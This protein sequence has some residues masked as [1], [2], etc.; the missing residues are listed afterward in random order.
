MNKKLQVFISSTFTDLIE[1]RQA[2]VE[3]ILNSGHI[4]AGMELFKGG[5]SI[6]KTIHKWIDESD[7][8]MLIL[9]G[10]YGAI[11]EKTGLSFTELEYNYAISKN[12]PVFAIV[13]D[14]KFLIF[15]DKCSDGKIDI[16]EQDHI[17]E[18]QSFKKNVERNVVKYVNNI[19]DLS[20]AISSH[21]NDLINESDNSLEG[22]IRNNKKTF[23]NSEAM[24][25]YI[26]KRIGEAKKSIYHLSWKDNRKSDSCRPNHVA[27]INFQKDMLATIESK[28]QQNIFYKD[29][30]TFFKRKERIEKMRTLIKYDSYWCGFFDSNEQIKK[31]PKLHFLIIDEIE[32][33]FASFDYNGNY[34]S[35]FD[36]E[37]VNIMLSY[38]DE[39]WSLCQKIKD[40]EG[41]HQNTY[42]TAV[43]HYIS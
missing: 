16:F 20:R 43:S 40:Y 37:I 39:C 12:M 23:I 22:W 6:M 24:D 31:F 17:A 1:E 18:Y 2:A 15:K 19:G 27:Y 9:G 41:F 5:K 38:F 32:V 28:L 11:D 14:K 7:V 21:L 3:E 10:R 34:C 26:I 42:E 29:I 35:V 33:L 8:Y 25:N 36:K 30:F 4:P 13:L